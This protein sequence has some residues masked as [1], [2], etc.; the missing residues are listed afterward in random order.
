MKKSIL[1]LVLVVIS[2][3]TGVQSA[4]ASDLTGIND[5]IFTTEAL[6][7]STPMGTWHLVH[8]AEV[9]NMSHTNIKYMLA[10]LKEVLIKN[11]DRED[12]DY[13]FCQSNVEEIE[14]YL[15]YADQVDDCWLVAEYELI[16]KE[17]ID[18]F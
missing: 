7:V 10:S 1:T 18:M 2:V 4:N 3:F 11:R 9:R 5:A 15:K 12:V 17:M 6:T 8:P 13:G 14:L 16:C